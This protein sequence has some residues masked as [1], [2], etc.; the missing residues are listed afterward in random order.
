MDYYNRIIALSL[1]SI[2]R[3]FAR[4]VIINVWKMMEGFSVNINEMF[5]RKVT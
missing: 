5:V 2:Q 4:L 3:R 1:S